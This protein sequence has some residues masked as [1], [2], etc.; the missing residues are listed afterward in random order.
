[1]KKYIILFLAFGLTSSFLL[2]QSFTTI[3]NDTIVATLANSTIAQYKIQQVNNTGGV[4]SLDIEVVGN[5]IPVGWDGMVC[6]QGICLGHIPAVGFTGSQA[7][8]NAN[9]TGYVRLTAD[10]MTVGGGGELR[11]Y[12][13]DVNFPLD[14]DTLTWIINPAPTSIKEV[15]SK[16]SANISP[17]P[18]K[19]IVSI[20]SESKMNSIKIYSLT[21][22]LVHSIDVINSKELKID[23]KQFPLGIYLV[24]IEGDS[25][26]SSSQKL[27][28]Q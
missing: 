14:G 17:N 12:V 22:E 23:V 9:D 5:T 26:N 19:D 7:N 4:L 18:S 3:P 21:G 1:M 2:A 11:I 28:V 8:L 27:I 6:L 10:P 16:L 15:K 25:N 20:V 13:F 24:R